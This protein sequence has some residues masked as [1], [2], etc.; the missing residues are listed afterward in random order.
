M[1]KTFCVA[2][3]HDVHVTSYGLFKG[4]CVQ[5]TGPNKGLLKTQGEP[6]S[7]TQGLDAAR[8]SDTAK[9]IRKACLNDQWHPECVRCMKEEQAGMRSMRM[10]YNERWLEDFSYNDAVACTEEDGTT[11]VEPFFYDI[12]L[13]NFCNAKC[14]ICN[15][16]TS[17]SWWQDAMKMHNIKSNTFTY[18]TGIGPMQITYHGGKKFTMEPDMYAWAN[19]DEFWQ[20]MQSKL[21]NIKHLYLIGGEPMMVHRHFDFLQ[22]CVD[23]GYSKNI[24]LQYD[25][26]LTNIPEHVLT[27]W[28]KFKK[29]MIGASIDGFGKALEY[30]RHPI[31]WNQLYKNLQRLDELASHNPSIEI[32]DS[33]TI[34]VF[35]CLHI[36]DYIEWKIKEGKHTKV[37]WKKHNSNMGAHM[38][39][40]PRYYSVGILPVQG[41][42][43]LI[44]KCN[45]WLDKM[46]QWIASLEHYSDV[47]TPD[48][49]RDNL[50][51]WTNRYI[52]FIDNTD[53]TKHLGEFW[54][55]TNKLDEIRN[56]KFEE[57]FPLEKQWLTIEE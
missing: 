39:H 27:L 50:I 6:I 32:F 21:P 57:V 13:G 28:T 3:W 51:K 18:P 40:S 5:S 37:L 26:N 44:E 55:K 31:K 45:Q 29:V 34:S 10:M 14:R 1:S 16:K 56:E 46:L 15:P 11:D 42:K 23:S 38:L 47:Q 19:S 33:V 2:P 35:N 53:E 30:Q 43:A 20:E 22:V 54:R 49:L 52:K 36:L 25:T 9:E 24:T 8:N 4:C 17:S 12:Q 7:V 48:Q 41:K